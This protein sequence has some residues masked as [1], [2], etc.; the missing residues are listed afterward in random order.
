MQKDAKYLKDLGKQIDKL[1]KER[2]LS[3]QEMAMRCEM[4]KAHAYRL[5]NEGMNAT[6][7]TL[8]KVAKGLDATVQDLFNFKY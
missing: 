6:A 3:F 1:R 4:D 8:L 7:L 2:G 5:C